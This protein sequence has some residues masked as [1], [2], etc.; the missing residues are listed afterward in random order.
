ME[1]SQPSATPIHTDTQ[2]TVLQENLSS[3]QLAR[4]SSALGGIRL[5]GSLGREVPKSQENNSKEQATKQ[6][7]IFCQ[8]DI[9]E[10]Q[11]KLKLH[12]DR[13]EIEGLVDTGAD[14]TMMSQDT[15]NLV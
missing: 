13:I 11:P 12:L 6:T 5:L 3:E 8:I 4:G 14:I 1:Q 7:Q 9:D 15:W 2:S 10:K